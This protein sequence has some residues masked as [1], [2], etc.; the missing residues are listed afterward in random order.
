MKLLVEETVSVAREDGRACRSIRRREPRTKNRTRL[1]L[2]LPTRWQGVAYGSDNEYA[3]GDWLK[4]QTL[5]A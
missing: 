4:V 1:A 5:E 2:G 3:L